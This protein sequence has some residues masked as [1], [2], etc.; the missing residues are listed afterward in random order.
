MKPVAVKYDVGKDKHGRRV[1]LSR[2]EM[3][4]W[5][6]HVEAAN[7]RDDSQTISGLTPEVI[8]AMAEAVGDAAA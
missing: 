1:F 8:R 7:Q 5:E 6:I 4:G 2:T 3:Y